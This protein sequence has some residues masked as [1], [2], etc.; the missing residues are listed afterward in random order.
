M[1][2]VIGIIT[3]LKREQ[4]E[5][6]ED[7][8]FEIYLHMKREP[9]NLHKQERVNQMALYLKQLE[10]RKMTQ[11]Q[12]H[13]LDASGSDQQLHHPLC[14]HQLQHQEIQ[15]HHSQRSLHSDSHLYHEAN[16]L[17]APLPCSICRAGETYSDLQGQAH[18]DPHHLQP[19]LS[20]SRHSSGKETP[21][22]TPAVLC[23]LTL[24]VCE[25]FLSP[26]MLPKA[27]LP[28]RSA[29]PRDRGHDQ[30][31]CHSQVAGEHV[32]DPDSSALK[33]TVINT[34]AVSADAGGAMYQSRPVLAEDF[35]T[36][37][38][39]SNGKIR[40]HNDDCGNVL[41]LNQ[42][43]CNISSSEEG[44]HDVFQK[45][46]RYSRSQ[47]TDIA[48]VSAGRNKLKRQLSLHTEH[49]L[50]PSNRPKRLSDFHPHGI[51]EEYLKPLRF[52]DSDCSV[53]CESV[54]TI[55]SNA[56]TDVDSDDRVNESVNID[57][58]C[59][60]QLYDRLC[61]SPPLKGREM[62]SLGSIPVSYSDPLLPR[63]TL[64]S[65]RAD[66]HTSKPQDA[67]PKTYSASGSSD[68]DGASESLLDYTN[69]SPDQGSGRLRKTILEA[70]KERSPQSIDIPELSRRSKTIPPNTSFPSFLKTKGQSPQQ[71][72][73]RSTSIRAPAPREERRGALFLSQKSLLHA[74]GTPQ[75]RPGAAHRGVLS[76][77]V[78]LDSSVMSPPERTTFVPSLEPLYVDSLQ[79]VG[80]DGLNV[81]DP[82]NTQR[83]QVTRIPKLYRSKTVDASSI[84]E[85]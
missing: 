62:Y 53:A 25:P 11:K 23:S 55:K 42:L 18:L 20:R 67:R 56:E 40:A 49:S 59:P 52:S 69:P 29:T 81:T 47:S 22:G 46:P 3:Y 70:W 60:Y 83:G 51:E 5:M 64:Q 80:M 17:S 76:R 35:Y 43:G 45:P 27:A 16:R 41:E 13:R 7:K 39:H 75:S 57:D 65:P 84:L 21:A 33:D 4:A 32:S 85:K 31:Q 15:Q 61:N 1:G 38:M 30:L 44:N 14:P 36:E 10:D 63:R 74:S 9:F 24:N 28:F 12:I 54:K 78:S 8:M 71:E 73:T 50:S 68:I 19:L 37:T 77:Q 79:P 34:L 66:V 82:S 2:I 58:I 26:E 72:A 48:P 6:E